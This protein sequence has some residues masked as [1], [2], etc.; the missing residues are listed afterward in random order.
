MDNKLVGQ[1]I[2]KY[3]RFRDM[4]QK[5]LAKAVGYATKSSINKIEAGDA[6]VPIPRLTQI[7]NA[8]RVPL[9]A[10]MENIPDDG[11]PYEDYSTTEVA[12]TN[13]SNE[14]EFV[15]QNRIEYMEIGELKNHIDSEMDKMEQ[16]YKFLATFVEKAEAE[17]NALKKQE[18]QNGEFMKKYNRLTAENKHTLNAMLDTMLMAQKNTAQAGGEDLS[19]QKGT[20]SLQ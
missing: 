13:Q 14:L 11:M 6:S 2:R 15:V 5:E 16:S 10:L 18:V 3:R 17:I 9:Q 7:A 12:S 1:N 4:S 20:P 8:L 19:T